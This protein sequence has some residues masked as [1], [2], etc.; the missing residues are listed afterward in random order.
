MKI[1]NKDEYDKELK[2]GKKLSRI[3]K[4]EWKEKWLWTKIRN[5]W[6]NFIITNKSF[7]GSWSSVVLTQCCTF[8]VRFVMNRVYKNE[9]RSLVHVHV[10]EN[11][12]RQSKK[13]KRGWQYESMHGVIQHPSHVVFCIKNSEPKFMLLVLL[14]WRKVFLMFLAREVTSRVEKKWKS[15]DEK[16]QKWDKLAALRI[17]VYE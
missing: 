1:H 3:G 6:R 4:V 17:P 13:K 11:E 14:S 15:D 12:P 16:T 7:H 10:T 8:R 5:E 2:K 9:W